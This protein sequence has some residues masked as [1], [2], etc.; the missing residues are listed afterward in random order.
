MVYEVS[1][2]QT[3]REASRIFKNTIPFDPPR[4]FRRCADDAV[5]LFGVERA[6]NHQRLGD[7]QNRRAML[8]DKRLGLGK[9]ECQIGIDGGFAGADD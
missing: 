1:A 6:L 2:F 4:P 7:C 5:N 8:G 9:P 3:N